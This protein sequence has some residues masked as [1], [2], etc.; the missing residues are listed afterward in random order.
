MKQYAKQ[1]GPSSR[2]K[3]KKKTLIKS[4]FLIRRKSIPREF[5]KN[6]KLLT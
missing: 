5:I 3:Q 6:L 1:N 2:L 4:S